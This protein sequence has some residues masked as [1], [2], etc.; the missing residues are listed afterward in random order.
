MRLFAAVLRTLLRQN[1]AG[2]LAQPPLPT[3]ETPLPEAADQLG[4]A[5]SHPTWIVLRW[6]HRWGL[7]DTLACLTHNNRQASTIPHLA[8][9]THAQLC[10]HCSN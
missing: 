4:V 8:Y 2:E 7:A 1:D 5:T 10:L 3:S 9:A 6:L